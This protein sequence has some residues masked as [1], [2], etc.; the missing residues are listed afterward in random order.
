LLDF[1]VLAE[2]ADD[3]ACVAKLTGEPQL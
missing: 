2:P 1:A 3:A